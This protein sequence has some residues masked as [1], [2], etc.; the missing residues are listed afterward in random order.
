MKSFIRLIL[1]CL[2]STQSAFAAVNINTASVEELDAVKYITPAKARA[3]VDYR[4]KNGP[5]KSLDELK[6]IKGFKEKSIAK[7]SGE[8]TVNGESKPV[9]AKPVKK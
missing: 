4:S 7:L 9:A 1:L 8:L 3:I 2:A 5:F 6:N